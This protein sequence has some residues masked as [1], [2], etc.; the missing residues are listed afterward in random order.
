MDQHDQITGNNR[1]NKGLPTCYFLVCLV[2]VLRDTYCN[3]RPT[4]APHIPTVAAETRMIYCRDYEAELEAEKD[5]QES[6]GSKGS[7]QGN[8]INNDDDQT[9]KDHHGD[10]RHEGQVP[11]GVATLTKKKK[12]KK[13]KKKTAKDGGFAVAAVAGTPVKKPPFR[14][15]KEEALTDYYVK[16][17]QTEPPTIPGASERMLLLP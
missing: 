2:H 6:V 7:D 15:L 14:G 8:P 9:K 12:H 13:K 10:D 11:D 4:E 3:P 1:I 5:T 16:L 17:G